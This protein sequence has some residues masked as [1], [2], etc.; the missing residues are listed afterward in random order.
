MIRYLIAATLLF[1][2]TVLAEP[3][4][5][6][7]PGQFPVSTGNFDEDNFSLDGTTDQ[8]EWVFQS[9]T[10]SPITQLCARYNDSV[11][12]P[13]E[14]KISLQGVDETSNPAASDGTVKES[15][16]AS[17]TFTPPADTSWDN[18]FQCHTLT[19][20][21]TPSIGERLAIV[22]EDSGT[23]DGSNYGQWTAT[24]NNSVINTLTEY[25]IVT[26]AGSPSTKDREYPIYA[27][28]TASTTYGRPILETGWNFTGPTDPRF[29]SSDTPDERGLRFRFG[30]GQTCTYSIQYIE[31]QGRA[32]GAGS[33]TINLRNDSDTLIDSATYDSDLNSQEGLVT[34]VHRVWFDDGDSLNCNDW[35][36][37]TLV[38]GSDDTGL[39]YVEGPAAADMDA[40]PGGTNFYE[41]NR[42]NA[43]SWT[44]DTDRRPS[45]ALGIFNFSASGG[46][47]GG[48]TVRGSTYN[49]HYN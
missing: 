25:A 7:I 26:N 1:S 22:I 44:N 38:P 4:E 14:Y 11:G 34:G 39:D 27:Y 6:L 12:T 43:G 31:W 48:S 3:I 20:S 37:V 9:E 16:N 40:L 32:A 29:N 46:G 30:E 13:P 2:S 33:I 5:F 42:T 18:T 10:S 21:Y 28:K 45:I 23:P 35:Y 41:T 17:A 19:S 8:I 49:R 47:G 36:R 24:W 15:G